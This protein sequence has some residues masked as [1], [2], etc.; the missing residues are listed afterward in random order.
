MCLAR[1][2]LST[3]G[4][5]R[6][7]KNRDDLVTSAV[8]LI[9]EEV[10][11]ATA[12]D[13]VDWFDGVMGWMNAIRA[14]L[15]AHPWAATRLGTREG[16]SSDAWTD[17]MRSLRTT[18][19]SGRPLTRRSG[20][21]V[22]VDGTTHRRLHHPRDRWTDPA[23]PRTFRSSSGRRRAGKDDR[24]GLLGRS[25]RTDPLVLDIALGVITTRTRAGRAALIRAIRQMPSERSCCSRR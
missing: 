11:T 18:P 19:G 15:L 12:D 24:R 20:A 16:G 23:N 7:V 25:P 17:A 8:A 1:V 22:Y 14:C 4:V 3:M 13:R 2:G 21:G 6:H 5:Y 9:L 10:A